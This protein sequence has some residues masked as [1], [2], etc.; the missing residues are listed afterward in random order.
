MTIKSAAI[1]KK[2]LDLRQQFWPKV[3]AS[4][5]WHRKQ[6]KGFTTI[7][8]SMPLICRIMNDLSKG[9]PLSAVYLDLWCRVYEESMVQ[10]TNHQELAFS[11]GFSGQR[12]VQTWRK[13]I[14]KLQQL[15]FIDLATGSQG[16]LSFALI[17]NPY[18]VVQ[19]HRDKKTPGLK[20]DS[21][22]ALLQRSSSIGA[23]DLI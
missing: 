15:K 4:R 20:M 12:G 19:Y 5:L 7:P 6:N 18:Q 8:R 1:S 9:T 14:L 22:N 21:Y 17:F 2:N 13:R 3:D 11:S 10:L 23:T 16:D